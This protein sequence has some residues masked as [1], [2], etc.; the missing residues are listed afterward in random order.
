MKPLILLILFAFAVW[1]ENNCSF[2]IEPIL[3]L[4]LP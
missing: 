2:N 4:T 1:L 3:K